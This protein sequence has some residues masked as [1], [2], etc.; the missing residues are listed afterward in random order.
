MISILMGNFSSLPSLNVPAMQFDEKG[1]FI[2]Q[3]R[4]HP[5]TQSFFLP[6]INITRPTHFPWS[7][8]RRGSL[9]DRDSPSRGGSRHSPGTNNRD[10]A[11]HGNL[12][13]LVVYLAASSS[14]VVSPMSAMVVAAVA[15]SVR[16]G[17]PSGGRGL[18]VVFFAVV[19]W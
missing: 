17:R 18:I 16:R 12:G 8:F 9:L 15:L 10:G 11:H 5:T 4:L 6:V 19:G 14:F 3:T 7:R 2:H 13:I 1:N